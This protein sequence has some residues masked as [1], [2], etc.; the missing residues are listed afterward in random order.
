MNNNAIALSLEASFQN[1]ISAILKVI[2]TNKFT[3]IKIQT[4]SD[5]RGEH[6]EETPDARSPCIPQRQLVIW[7]LVL[8]PFLMPQQYPSM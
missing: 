7:F 3:H 8:L 4:G 1:F 5:S 6:T 2:G